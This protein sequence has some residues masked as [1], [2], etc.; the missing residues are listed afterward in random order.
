MIVAADYKAVEWQAA[1]ELCRDKVGIEEWNGWS[2]GKPDMHNFNQQ[3]F[4]LPDRRIAKIF[5]FRL[6]YG[7]TEW[8]YAKDPDYNWISDSPKYWRDMIDGFYEKYSGLYRWHGDLVRTVTT[9][10]MLSIPT[11]R[12][13]YF[14]PSRKRGELVWPRTQILNYPVQGFA[15]EWVK[16]GRVVLL[17]MLR[18]RLPEALF[19]SSVH[20]SLVLDVREQDVGRALQLL[21]DVVHTYTA[22][23]FSRLYGYT[24]AMPIRGEV[25]YGPNQ[26]DLKEWIPND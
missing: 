3:K 23:V 8:S 2:R 14:T 5:L 22:T 1:L 15:S 10:G 11:G 9:K 24:F 21:Y 25:F 19:I 13:Y 4:N 12:S 18:E 26:K 17:R 16:V 7:G 20:D 6:I